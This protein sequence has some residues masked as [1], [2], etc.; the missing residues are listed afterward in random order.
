M[1]FATNVNIK[2]FFLFFLHILYG[3]NVYIMTL[4]S[5]VYVIAIQ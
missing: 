1:F 4:Y 5:T 2:S 3:L